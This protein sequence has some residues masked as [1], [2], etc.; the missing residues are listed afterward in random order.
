[1]SND[2]FKPGDWNAI[3]DTCGRK[4]KASDLQLQWD[5]ARV[6]QTCW[7]P[8]HPQE[9]LGPLPVP[10]SPPWTRPDIDPEMDFT[11]ERVMDGAVMDSQS[12]G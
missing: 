4:Y 2:F 10:T 9:L 5:N 1:M 3:C 7:D 8:R 12:M 6:C 11:T